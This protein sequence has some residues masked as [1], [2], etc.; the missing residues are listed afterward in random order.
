[1]QSTGPANRLIRFRNRTPLR[2]FHDPEQDIDKADCT[3]GLR[4]RHQ[5]HSVRN[6]TQ[7]PCLILAGQASLTTLFSKSTQQRIGCKEKTT[8]AN[9]QREL[10]NQ[11]RKI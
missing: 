3:L 1:M 2:P 8:G 5:N 9:L 7:N 11:T 10:E 6:Q 4:Q